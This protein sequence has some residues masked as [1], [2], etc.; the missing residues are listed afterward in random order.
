MH[1]FIIAIFCAF[2]VAILYLH[3]IKVHASP[4]R[5]VLIILKRKMKKKNKRQ[6]KSFKNQLEQRITK[7]L[8]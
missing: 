1:F 7:E 6:K 2:T 5:V 4:E 3:R 8:N